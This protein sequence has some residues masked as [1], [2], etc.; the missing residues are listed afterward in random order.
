MVHLNLLIKFPILLLPSPL[1]LGFNL[2]LLLSNLSIKPS[3]A[4]PQVI[5]PTCP[6]SELLNYSSLLYLR[7]NQVFRVCG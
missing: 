1:I 3:I 4:Q 2:I 7:L 5:F 6:T